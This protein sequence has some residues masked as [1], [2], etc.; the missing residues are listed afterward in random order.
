MIFYPLEG[1][2]GKSESETVANGD[3]LNLLQERI[4]HQI[5]ATDRFGRR[6]LVPVD[7]GAPFLPVTFFLFFF[8]FGERGYVHTR[9]P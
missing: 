7:S 6:V 4:D 8:L 9:E 1:F 3:V 2:N 5:Y